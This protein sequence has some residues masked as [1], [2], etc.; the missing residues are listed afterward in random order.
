MSIAVSLAPLF[1]R[2]AGG[3][4]TPPTRR[5][6]ACMATKSRAEPAALGVLFE[7]MTGVN[8]HDGDATRP[9]PLEDTAKLFD[10]TVVDPR[11]FADFIEQ[12]RELVRPDGG[13]PRW[14]SPL[15]CGGS[16]HAECPPLFFLP[17]IDGVG[18]GLV[19]HHQRLGKI[20]DVWC[21]H[22]P[23]KDRTSFE[24]LVNY[25]E[26]TVRS[27]HSWKPNTPIYLVGE[28]LGACIALAVAARNPQIDFVLI[29]A[30]PATSFSGSQLQYLLN[31]L[32]FVPEPLHVVIPFLLDCFTGKTMRMS[33]TFA[34]DKFSVQ[35]IVSSLA[36]S[37]TR[38]LV[39]L[40]FLADILPKD[41][42]LWKL[43]VLK[44]ASSYVNSRL[45][46][47]KA[48]TLLLAS[49][50]DEL[51]PSGEEAKR[52]C[53]ILPNSRVRHFNNS[54]HRLFL[55]GTLDLVTVI[56]GS[57]YYR[58]SWNKDY[59][60]DYLPPTPYEFQKMSDEYKWITMA[61]CPVMLSTL[62][63][64][65]IVKG[66]TGIP[67]DG[68]VLFVGNHMLMGY[69]LGP[70]VISFLRERNIHLRGI[71]HP[72]I[73]NRDTEL[74]MFDSSS[75]DTMRIMGA[76]PVSGTTL[77]KL[78]SRKSYILLYPGG[79]REALHKKGEQYKLFWPAQAEF[80]RMA[81]RFGATI[82]PFGVVGEDDILEMLL[83]YN[84]LVKIPFYELLDRRINQKAV[85]L[86]A[87]VVEEVGNQE[88]HLPG[89]LPKIPGRFYYLFGKPIP[90]RELCQDRKKAQEMYLHVKSEVKA[91][92]LI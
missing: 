31:T 83:D 43:K 79:A 55:E 15:D 80:V 33:S 27:K 91:A 69:E 57:N 81:S 58:R 87:N 42:L 90:T 9:S 76:V 52:L 11:G 23:V 12:S 78:L 46:S 86:R 70:L 10:E 73:F 17:G 14:L 66:L 21:L 59:V 92:L 35:Q 16:R 30:N 82:V 51:F 71:A 39:S 65:Q 63:S 32:D 4:P 28:S 50:M 68:P 44:S 47:V 38:M 56:K 67:S 37:Q 62:V 89:L 5:H 45:H 25:V 3:L 36:E 24:G 74:L 13:P 41:T 19:R 84:D 22:I 72:F 1:P 61:T 29:L 54:S 88:L 85:R 8:G 77:Y 53:K 60:S 20:F 6:S 48:Q 2:K 40:S 26:S 34:E 75:F 49:G 64:G 7:L 18:L